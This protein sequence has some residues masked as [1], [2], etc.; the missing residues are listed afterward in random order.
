MVENSEFP[1]PILTVE[2]SDRDDP[3]NF[4]AVRYAII[5]P[6]SHLFSIDELA[7]VVQVAPGA[8]ID[9]EADSSH[10]IYVLALDTPLGGPF[11]RT[12]MATLKIQVTGG[13]DMGIYSKHLKL[14]PF[15]PIS[16]LTRQE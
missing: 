1:T 4:G 14:N 15:L 3:E 2:A 8:D 16:I 9:R 10:T 13:Y 5:G 6:Q 12:T 7:G 11:Q